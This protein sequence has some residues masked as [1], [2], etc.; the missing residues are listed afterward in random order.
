MIT[1]YT[2]K[3]LAALYNTQAIGIKEIEMGVTE[4]FYPMF[5]ALHQLGLGEYVAVDASG[6]KGYARICFTK[7]ELNNDQLIRFN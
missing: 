6:D 1:L 5:Y 2:E 3:E 7:E 4:G